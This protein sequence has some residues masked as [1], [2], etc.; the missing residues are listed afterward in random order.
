MIY[1]GS[2]HRGFDLKEKIKIW[3]SSQEIPFEDLG[4]QVL[5][6]EDD[7]PDFAKTVLEKVS[8]SSENFGILFCGS[9][10]GVDIVANRRK[11]I[12]SVLGFDAKQVSSA[13]SD[14]NVN[15]LSL[16]SDFTSE[17]TIKELILA[18]LKTPFS[19]EEKHQRRIEKIDA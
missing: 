10:A 5:D 9:G 13:R 15:V 18:F 12:R 16:A 14:D 17:E 8:Q 4:N 7:Y 11:G 1:L 19:Q 3:L 6:P 2:D